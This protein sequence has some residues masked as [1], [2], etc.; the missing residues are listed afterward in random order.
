[1]T[2]NQHDFQLDHFGDALDTQIV[3]DGDIGSYLS[4][5]GL[6]E[7]LSAMNS[8]IAG[9]SG[10]SG[11]AYLIDAVDSIDFP[12]VRFTGTYA[13]NPANWIGGK[14][15]DGGDNEA[16]LFL[17]ATDSGYIWSQLNVTKSGT[18]AADVFL[19][20][21]GYIYTYS[22]VQTQHTTG[23]E[24]LFYGTGIIFPVQSSDPSSPSNGQVYYNTTTHKLR[25]R[26]NGGWV[27]LN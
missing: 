6:H 21:D 16:R 3:I 8:G 12:G 24:H 19:D 1:M 17:D 2:R 4:G 14:G 9:G 7:V 15:G 27:D 13:G 18:Q 20:S 25:L 5:T 10:G 23:T 26:A 11:L 22:T